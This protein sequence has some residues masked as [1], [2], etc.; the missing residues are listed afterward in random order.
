MSYGLLAAFSTPEA[1]LDAARRARERG[2]VALDAFTPYP[3]EGLPELVGVA[4]SRIPLWAFIGGVAG[5]I[6]IV[7]LQLYSTTIAY[8]INVGGRPLDSW[9]AFAV[10][11]FECVVLGAALVAFLG[12]LAGNRLPQLYHP[13]FNAPSFSLAGGNRFYLLVRADDP[14]FDRRRLRDMLRRLEPLSLEEVAE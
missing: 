13:V 7:G 12:M 1:L 9:T 6:G 3:V 2:Y 8:P 11:G 10:P 4:P 5:G 14:A